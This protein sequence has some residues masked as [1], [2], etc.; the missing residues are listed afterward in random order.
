MTLQDQDTARRFA[1]RLFY[2]GAMSLALMT[3]FFLALPL[4]FHFTGAK[5]ILWP[6]FASCFLVSLALSIYIL[7][8]AMLYRMISTYIDLP[9]G[10]KATDVLLRR[11]GLRPEPQELRSLQGRMAGTTTLLYYQRAA[12]F[13]LT[14]LFA[15]MAAI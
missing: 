1:D 10:L 13:V 9:S 12:L 8:D 7:F 5:I 4:F 11:T 14:L 6:L 3:A 2:N 15:A